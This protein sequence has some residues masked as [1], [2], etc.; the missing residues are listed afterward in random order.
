M[1]FYE[2]AIEVLQLAQRPLHYKKITELAIKRN[3]LSHVGKTPEITMG[4]RL[5]QEI[6][7]MSDRT[8][9]VRTRPGVYGLRDWP[10]SMLYP[11]DSAEVAAPMVATP[12]VA[13]L[14][15]PEVAL[16]EVERS[17]I[18]SA[19]LYLD[20]LAD[21]FPS[22][23]SSDDDGSGRR[24][25]R[26][27]RRRREDGDLD[28]QVLDG[29]DEE[30]DG[31][32]G[33]E[34]VMA[35][36]T[37]PAAVAPP[38]AVFGPGPKASEPGREREHFNLA[39][40][41]LKELRGCEGPCSAAALAHLLASKHRVDVS[42][43]ALVVVL[44]ADCASRQ[45]RGKRALFDEQADGSWQLTERGL[46]KLTTKLEGRVYDA[47]RQ[48]RLHTTHAL[49]ARLQ[50]LQPQAWLKLGTL[51]LKHLGY[52][53]LAVGPATEEHQLF[54]VELQHA[55]PPV[56]AIAQVLYAPRFLPGHISAM[57]AQVRTSQ[58]ERGIILVNGEVTNEVLV[59]SEAP[60]CVL[61]V[62]GAKQAAKVLLENGIGVARHDVPLYSLDQAFFQ[63]LTVMVPERREEEGESA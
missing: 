48:L 19:E 13:A 26:R 59:D 36:A 31:E 43:Q 10:A 4:T 28:E 11:D 45:A 6:Q 14:P 51:L 58:V 38:V 21:V 27:R 24:R 20:A 8:V 15:A 41:A 32:D 34:E 61:T 30:L 22:E 53:V 40:A 5:V 3:L 47:A 52:S 49:S 63:D 23:A 16:R 37:V 54:R 39:A 25:R 1:T 42:E 46:S 33:V 17:P 44:R 62:I 57:L 2:A 35:E 29:Q 7:R 55:W 9:I 56:G 50:E 60:G 12:A 18:S